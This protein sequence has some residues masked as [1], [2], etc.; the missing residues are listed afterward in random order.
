MCV[1]APQMEERSQKF[2]L[3]RTKDTG[4]YSRFSFRWAFI[5]WIDADIVQDPPSSITFISLI[6]S[7]TYI[8]QTQVAKP[9]SIVHQIIMHHA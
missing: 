6:Q 4:R 8:H 2:V 7:H 9:S 5:F 3:R 1:C